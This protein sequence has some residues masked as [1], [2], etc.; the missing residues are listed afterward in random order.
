VCRLHRLVAFVAF[1]H[2]RPDI[3]FPQA[4]SAGA[5]AARIAAVTGLLESA[6]LQL[7]VAKRLAPRRGATL[8]QRL[9]RLDD[10]LVFVVGSP[11]SGTTFLGEAIGSLPGFVDLG[12]VAPLK[13]A[14]PGLVEVEPGAAARRIR[15]MLAVARR[16]GLVGA[17]RAVEQTP[18]TA[19]VL[20]AVRSAYPSASIVHIVRDGRDV[21]CSLI[22]KAWLSA[23]LAGRDDAGIRYG[24]Y[25]RFWVEPERR[26]EFAT[27]SDARRAA[28][29][30][31]R[32]VG[33]VRS[34]G[35]AVVDVRYERMAEH[36]D[37]VASELADALGA[38]RDPLAAALG[39]AHAASVGRHRRDLGEAD[40]TDVIAEAGPLL[41]DLGYL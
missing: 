28:W 29:A 9:G 26:D 41:R 36:P 6:A 16:V 23:E 13:A 2:P 4:G 37:E 21:A 17:V 18:E 30:W 20:E 33:A 1:F 5:P 22:D 3:G 38:P 35:V 7:R 11:R 40:L 27:V 39:R 25:A 14:I 32:Y 15:R 12:E 24:S 34:A 31:R 8:G 10:R 19:F